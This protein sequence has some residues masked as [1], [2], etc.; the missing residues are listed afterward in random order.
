MSSSLQLKMPY[1]V[2]SSPSIEDALWWVQLPLNQ[3]C[4]T[5]CPTPLNQIFLY[6]LSSSPIKDACYL[7]A[8]H[9]SSTLPRTQRA[10][11]QAYGVHNKPY[12]HIDNLRLAII[13][14]RRKFIVFQKVNLL[15]EVF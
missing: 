4:F 9:C 7:C 11:V 13:P 2:S 3:T 1:I 8:L 6:A 15:C 5:E 10:L 12:V 14:L